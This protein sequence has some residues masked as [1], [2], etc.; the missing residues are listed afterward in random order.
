MGSAAPRLLDAMLDRCRERQ[1]LNARGRQRPDATH[2][3]ARVRA[4][5]RVACVGAT[6]RS[7]LHRRAVGAPAWLH[8]HRQMA[9]E[10]RD[11]RRV[12]ADR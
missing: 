12:E 3:L 9:W 11:G 4:V 6:R 1:W 10:Q 8:A 2:G 7:A 5:K